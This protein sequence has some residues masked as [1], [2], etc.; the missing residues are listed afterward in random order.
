MYHILNGDCLLEQFPD[1]ILGKRIVARA[2]LVDGPVKA[3]SLQ[4]LYRM[5]YSFISSSYG[6][7]PETDYYRKTVS[8]FSHIQNIKDEA[9]VCLWF[10]DDL[11]CQVNCW[12]VLNLL[13]DSGYKGTVYLVRPP[14]LSQYGFGG[15]NTSELETLFQNKQELTKTD[16]WKQLWPLYQQQSL[17]AMIGV[18]E[19]LKTDYPFV[20]NA[21]QAHI[22]RLP[23]DHSEGK[24][25]KLLADIMKE[26]NTKEFG[27]VFQAFCKRAPIY[28]F[29]DLQV[30]RLF[31]ELLATG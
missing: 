16:I 9:T 18:G 2:C 26:L 8:G 12:F 17:E 23:S 20:F 21:I 30:K 15:F 14:A 5:R 11:F 22:D 4:A 19:A 25:K 24:P 10:E 29:G 1:Q 7:F 28:G 31:D 13:L 27:P 6:D 3:T